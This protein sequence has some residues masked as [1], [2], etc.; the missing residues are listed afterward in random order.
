MARKTKEIR[1]TSGT[2]E[3]NRDLGKVYMLTEMS[4]Y[5]A[6][7]WAADAFQGL[8]KA[9]VDVP[10]DL[11][12]AGMVAIATMGLKALGGMPSETLHDLLD[13]MMTQVTHFPDPNRREISRGFGSML[14]QKL[15]ADDIEEISTRLLLRQEL[16]QLHADF[17]MAGVQSL[18]APKASAL[19]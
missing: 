11:A 1:I 17:L 15:F 16:L 10:D 8:V 13:R 2:A 14:S 18:A 19:T 9:G 7:R 4:A 6:E 3:T 5:D 12:D